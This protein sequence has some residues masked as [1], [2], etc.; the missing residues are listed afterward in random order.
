MKIL[1]NTSDNVVKYRIVMRR[2]QVRKLCANHVITDQLE[3]KDHPSNDKMLVWIA[4]DFADEEKRLE[5][6]CAKFKTAEIKQQFREAF[7]KGVAEYNTKVDGAGKGIQKEKPKTL[8]EDEAP[9]VVEEIGTVEQQE[10]K[11]SKFSWFF[12]VFEMIVLE[13]INVKFGKGARFRI[14]G[15]QLRDI[16][17]CRRF[18]NSTF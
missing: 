3:P 11:P 15:Q 6:F 16:Q 1:K 9:T 4:T 12:K 10:S 5:Q 2:D 8:N 7:E 17:N 13:V 18:W 14:G